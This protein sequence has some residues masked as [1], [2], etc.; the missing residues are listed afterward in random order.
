MQPDEPVGINYGSVRNPSIVRR[1]PLTT[2]GKSETN[3][4]VYATIEKT[5]KWYYND[6]DWGTFDD[7]P[8]QVIERN[9]IFA[10]GSEVENAVISD[11]TRRVYGK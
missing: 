3:P 2:A 9:T 4:N 6:S 10:V 5:E 1:I 8:D 11:D 7:I